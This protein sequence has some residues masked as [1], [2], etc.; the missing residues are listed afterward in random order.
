MKFKNIIQFNQC[1]LIW[2]LV[3]AGIIRIVLLL[4]LQPWSN[5]ALDQ[6][7]FI[8]SDSDQYQRL[9]LEILRSGS[10]EEF[11]IF[12][13]P[14]YPA[15]IVLIYWIFGIKPWIVIVIQI[16]LNLCSILFLY[17]IGKLLFNN[18]ISS[19]AALLFS[20]D[21]FSI[22]YSLTILADTIFV[23]LLILGIFLF[24]RA[25]KIN[26]ILQNITAGVIFGSAVY[27]K[28]VLLYFPLILLIIYIFLKINRKQFIR[29][30]TSVLCFYMLL[31]PWYIRNYNKYGIIGF[32]S[33]EGEHT[34]K[35][36]ISATE[37]R[38]TGMT[39]SEARKVI[40]SDVQ[41]KDYY[42]CDNKLAKSKSYK[43]YSRNFIFNN[44]RYFIPVTLNGIRNT[45]LAPNTNMMFKYFRLTHDYDITGKSNFIPK[46]DVPESSLY[47]TIDLIKRYFA[48]RSRLEA[49]LGLGLIIIS[50]L[51]YVL[52]LTGLLLF[53]K[54]KKFFIITA[55]IFIYFILLTGIV[56]NSR[57]KLPFVPIISLWAA[58]GI[59]FLIG[60]TSRLDHLCPE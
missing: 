16:I 54:N 52:S 45:F 17:R 1:S 36:I 4:I 15:F 57:Y 18:R 35:Y 26:S 25:G 19:F 6:S 39:I 8:F 55:T 44:F 14:G 41:S 23:F 38:K 33:F 42:K 5:V 58:F 29:I 22:F 49:F 27:L 11:N 24:L 3:I 20:L 50:L 2:I 28:P 10:L 13:P 12:R 51:V 48:D 34:I 56:G 60:K 30:A 43:K 31:V 9:A 47:T 21:P 7:L 46:M 53:C 32:T 37:A 59:D 40:I